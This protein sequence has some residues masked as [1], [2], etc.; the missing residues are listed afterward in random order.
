MNSEFKE[1]VEG[2]KKPNSVLIVLL[3]AIGDVARALPLAYKIKNT[4]PEVKITWAVESSSYGLVKSCKYVDRVIEFKRSKGFSAFRA[5]ISEIRKTKYD[6]SFDLQRHFKSGIVNFLS[7]AKIRIAF[8]KANSRECNYLF[9]NYHIPEVVH[10]SD[11]IEQFLQFGDILG[12]K[13][14]EHPYDFG[15][16]VEEKEYDELKNKVPELSNIPPDKLVLFLV[17]STWKSRR[18][19]CESYA[20]VAN[21]LSYK[22]GMHSAVIGAP[23][24]KYLAEEIKRHAKVPILD[25]VGVTSLKDFIVLSKYSGFAIGSDSG[26]LHIASA[27]QLPVI[28]LWGPTSPIRSK[29][30]GNS[31]KV[32][33]SP[34]GCRECYQRVCPGLENYCLKELKPNVVMAM[35]DKIIN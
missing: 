12:L 5:F 9:S 10:F 7:S 6:I 28:S 31:D 13:K 3:G 21:E 24:E 8:N 2:K 35:V 30:Y 33:Q 27:M 16:R 15:L 26:P 18:W 20:E 14:I 23:H 19:P 17:G 22:Y 32:L 4:W 11:K 25:L 29:P 34:I 1:I